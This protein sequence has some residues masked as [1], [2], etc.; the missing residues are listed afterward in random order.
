MNI[1]QYYLSTILEKKKFFSHHRKSGVQ[2]QAKDL[3]ASFYFLGQKEPLI[4]KL[5]DVNEENLDSI[6]EIDHRQDFL[7]EYFIKVCKAIVVT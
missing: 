3:R 1:N 2:N 5:L 6:D 7:V 4:L